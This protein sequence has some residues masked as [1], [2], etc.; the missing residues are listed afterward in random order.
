MAWAFPPDLPG[1]SAS[2]DFSK[3]KVMNEILGKFVIV[4]TN[5]AGVHAGV[6]SK[7][8]GDEIILTNAR[9][10]WQF[11]AKGGIS[12]S[13]VAV[14]GIVP[15]KSR[16]CSPVPSIWIQAIEIIPASAAAEESIMGAKNAAP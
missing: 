16:I 4:R 8:D 9:R 6:L 14:N 15:E 5:S 3:G 1:A 11:F 2:G 13:E 12:L 10:L 7:K